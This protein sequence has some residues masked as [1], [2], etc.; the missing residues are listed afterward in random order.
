[1]S[2]LAISAALETKLLT[3]GWGA[4]RT[5]FENSA[6]EPTSG[7]AYQRIAFLLARPD[8]RENNAAFM[9]RGLMQVTFCFPANAG[10]GPALQR[11][12]QLRAA[13]P[14]GLTLPTDGGLQVIIDE[15]PEIGPAAIEA[16]RY[17]LP[18]RVR[19]YAHVWP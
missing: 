13:F 18:L 2:T 16:D 12:E 5:A 10:A 19:F 8:N 15:T 7:E 4:E 17:L 11:A 9:Q 6:F 1:M 3:L 14:R